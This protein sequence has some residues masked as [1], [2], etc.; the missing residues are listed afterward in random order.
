MRLRERLSREPQ[1]GAE[2]RRSIEQ[3][4]GVEAMVQKTE[5]LLIGLC[6]VD[7][8]ARRDRP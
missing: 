3:R 7:A 2:A 6:E 1:L 8:A 5:E 4:Y